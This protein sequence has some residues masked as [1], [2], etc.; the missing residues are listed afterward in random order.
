MRSM[1]SKPETFAECG[2]VLLHRS[3]SVWSTTPGDVFG[4]GQLLLSDGFI[5]ESKCIWLS[6][7][8]RGWSCAWNL[9]M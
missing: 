9:K 7:I 8:F 2:A 4:I 6:F 3:A 1:E 5:G